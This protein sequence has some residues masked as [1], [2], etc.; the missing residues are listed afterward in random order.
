MDTKLAILDK[1]SAKGGYVIIDNSFICSRLVDL[2]FSD[3]S[4][5]EGLRRSAEDEAEFYDDVSKIIGPNV[6][7]PCETAEE[8]YRGQVSLRRYVKTA[9]RAVREKAHG[10]G[11]GRHFMINSD[12]RAYLR[13]KVDIIKIILGT[14]NK[15]RLRVILKHPAEAH[16][17]E[18]IMRVYTQLKSGVESIAANLGAQ[19]IM[20]SDNH[21][22]PLPD[23]LGNDASIFAK[24]LALSTLK[25]AHLIT[26]DR[27]FLDISRIFYG[28][29]H[30]MPYRTSVV[31]LKKNGEFF[32][33]D[34]HSRRTL[35]TL[36]TT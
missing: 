36:T 20:D 2:A 34:P 12:K 4:D 33:V 28:G 10:L 6:L 7:F 18:P 26:R 29:L 11:K 21:N 3:S 8:F 5:N 24:T 31:Y 9:S 1:F 30:Q 16:M 25:P 23:H 22:N 15:F 17:T 27:D 19:K 32:A 35:E 13:E 14:I